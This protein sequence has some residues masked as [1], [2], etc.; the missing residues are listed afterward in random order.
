MQLDYSKE[1]ETA[2][3]GMT[4]DSYQNRNVISR[5]V[6]FAAV[7]FGLGLVYGTDKEK[8]VALPYNQ[9]SSILFDADF[10]TSNTI[11]L[12]VNGVSIATVTF[13]TDHDTTA[14]L[15]VVAIAALTGVTC[16][17]DSTDATNR[18]FI[19]TAI[20]TDIAVTNIVVAAGGSQAGGVATNS[21]VDVFAGIAGHEHKQADSDGVVNYKVTDAVN[22]VNEGKIWVPVTGAVVY[23]ETAYVI[24]TGAN[25]GKFTN[26]SS[27]T[28]T[29][30]AKFKTSTTAAGRAVVKLRL[31]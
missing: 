29:T 31:L 28:L 22:V 20:G 3:D 15:L 11:D 7:V 30:G 17:L 14:A 23:D 24:I 25:K 18:T 6:E 5:A 8:Q 19:I 13:T 4:A 1:M 2:F 16:V 27:G 9:T 21:T 26:S 10:V 12:D